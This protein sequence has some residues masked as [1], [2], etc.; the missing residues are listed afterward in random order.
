M[1][2]A[3]TTEA[4]VSTSV[5]AYSRA[6]AALADTRVRL[7]TN[8]RILRIG[9]DAAS[10]TA[11]AG[12]QAET[13]TLRGSL[14]SG[15]RAGSYL[16]TAAQGLSQIHDVLTDLAALAT[17]AS[18]SGITPHGATYLDAQF[19]SALTGIDRIVAAT[20]F[21]GTRLLDG[22]AAGAAATEVT[23]GS[24]ERVALALPDVS[25]SSLFTAPVTLNSQAAATS[26]AGSVT[27]AQQAVNTAIAQVDAYQLRLRVADATTSHEVYGVNL[28]ITSLLS[29]DPVAESRT[30]E[31]LRLQQDT[32]AVILAQAMR[33]NTDL[34]Q[35]VRA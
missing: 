11:A 21:N 22:S 25:R 23:L 28:A 3:A 32:S 18:G 29:T 8:E 26:A 10:I 15:A 31:H 14:A 17:Q 2:F 34:L 16:Q 35:L 20:T 9:D 5:A 13:A 4:R 12:L 27:T 7:A 19:Q 24:G 6:S 30:A 33:F 1:T